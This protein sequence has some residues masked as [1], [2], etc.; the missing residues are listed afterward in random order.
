MNKLYGKE[1]LRILIPIRYPVGGIRTYLKYTHGILEK[2]QYEFSF[3]APSIEWLNHIKNDFSDFKVKT[4]STKKGYNSTISLLLSIF[5]ALLRDEYDLIHSQG[6]TAGIVS[7][8]AHIVFRLPHI[9]TLHHVFGERQFSDSFWD[10]YAFLKKYAIEFLLTMA[11]VI[12][13]VSNDAQENLLQYFPGL[14]KKPEKLK[15]IRNGI[16]IKEFNYNNRN[17]DIPF[18]KEKG[19]F[20]MGFLGRYMPEKG[21]EYIIRAVDVL[22]NESETKNIR[23]ISVGGF[24][25]FIREYQKEIEAMGLSRY[26]EFLHFFE[27]VTPVLKN[28]ELLLIPSLG[29]S[30]GLVPMEGL[31]CATPII[32]FSCLGVRE[33]L[34]NTPAIMVPLRDI[35]RTANEI[36]KM[37][38]DYGNIKRKFED[39]EP[40]AR[41]RF[42]SR[43]TAKNLEE[44]FY[45][46]V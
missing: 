5:R 33:V 34:K 11:D 29:E 14:R 1:R 19:T 40:E 26:F 23:V 41:K 43:I 13:T 28:I 3:L 38:N 12:Q 9:I 17:N 39:F 24:G 2:D 16:N 35:K 8:L 10:K 45:N 22:V 4:I 37:M 6:Y 30:C 36:L 44:L 42:D 25:G 18:K 31:V 15:A 46:L 21:F 20:Y 27:N 7:I 32:A